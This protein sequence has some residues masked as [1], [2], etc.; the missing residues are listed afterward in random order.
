MMIIIIFLKEIPSVHV[1]VYG[2]DTDIILHDKSAIALLH[3]VIQMSHNVFVWLGGKI[4]NVF[5]DNGI[6]LTVAISLKIDNEVLCEDSSKL[7]FRKPSHFRIKIDRE[8]KSII[9][10]C[11]AIFPEAE[12]PFVM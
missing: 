10:I 5:L 1:A 11:R 6:M 9:I 3:Y 8:N 4:E 7:L 12:R 2:E